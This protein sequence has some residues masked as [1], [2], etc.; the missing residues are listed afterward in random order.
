MAQDSQQTKLRETTAYIWDDAA[1]ALRIAIPEKANIAADTVGRHA[2]GPKRDHTALIFEDGEGALHRWTFAEVDAQATRLAAAL[3]R[4]GV[5]RGARVALHSGLRP[6][7]AIAHMAIYKLGA[8]VVTLSQLYGPDTVGHVLNHSEA[9]AIVTQDSAWDRFRAQSFP[10]LRHR[11]VIGEAEGEELSFQA[12]SEEPAGDFLPA[13]TAADDPA[14]LMYTSGST[15]LPK[16]LLHGHRILHAYSPTVSLFYNLEL[17]EPDLVC[18]TPADWAWVGGLLDLLLPAWE[19]GQT[20]VTSESRFS[21]EWAF[22]FMER[23]GVTHSFM[24][25]TALKRL[26]EVRDAASR[27][28]LKLRTVCTGGE[29]LPA[30]TWK[31]LQDELG[32]CC[33]EFY[34]LTEVNHLIGCCQAL[35]PSLPGSMGKAFPGHDIAVVDETGAEVPDGEIGQIVAR[36]DDPTRFLG[37][38]KNPELTEAMKLGRWLKTGD[39][40]KRDGEGYFWYQGRADDL[41][42]TAGYR[43]G[44]GEVENALL[45]HEAVAEAAVIPSPDPDR[46]SIVK[47]LVR[48]SAGAIGSDE[49][50]RELQE[51]VK[52]SLAAYKYPREIDFVESLPMT[53]S[54]KINR[55]DLAR[56]ERRRKLGSAGS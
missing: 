48:L 55:K 21:A 15:G 54:G 43:V 29:A 38:W 7:T 24:T 49:L 28:S 56:E 32:I 42:K 25:P 19:H 31:W 41:I 30:E 22:A 14:L 13:E 2:K 3:K 50:R 37:Y 8:L 27:W 16:G 11:I 33:N 9:A 20:V 52:Q 46:G 34:G 5:G 10:A 40:A 44:P 23:H 36:N 26:A 47:A 18:W 6:E 53:S 51:M 12:L 17:D 35:Y 1:A 45:K 39:L 4:R